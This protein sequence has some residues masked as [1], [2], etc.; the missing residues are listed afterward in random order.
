MEGEGRVESIDTAAI[1]NV[2]IQYIS[3][4]V[5]KCTLIGLK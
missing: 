5:Q 2:S 1:E 3:E 4:A